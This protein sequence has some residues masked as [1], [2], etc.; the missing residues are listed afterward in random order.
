M[1]LAARYQ[2]LTREMRILNKKKVWHQRAIHHLL[3]VATLGGQTRY[4]QDYV[5]T[6]GQT[7]YVTPDWDARSLADRYATLRHERV[8][9]QQF[10]RYGFVP[11]AIAYLLLPLPL[12]LAW[13]RMRL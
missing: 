13:C 8:H 5:T 4:L 3:C 7:I 2:E 12:G 10:R 1:D 9:M 11:M 6:L